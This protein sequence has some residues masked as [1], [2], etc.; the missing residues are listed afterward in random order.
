MACVATVWV[1]S[2]KEKVCVI[3][4]LRAQGLEKGSY[5]LITEQEKW[6]SHT[7]AEMWRNG[8]SPLC[9]YI[10]TNHNL[11]REGRRRPPATS[12]VLALTCVSRR[13]S[14]RNS[15]TCLGIGADTPEPRLSMSAL[16]IDLVV[17]VAKDE[18]DNVQS[19]FY[20]ARKPL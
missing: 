5:G 13:I 1:A 7:R 19:I 16:M 20:M 17:V 12:R 15:K 3:P 10:V 4:S 11:Q 6:C 9:W 18:D 8:R 14:S 2:K